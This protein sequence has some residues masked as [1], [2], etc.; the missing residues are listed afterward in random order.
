MTV[1]IVSDSRATLYYGQY[2]FAVSWHQDEIN[3]IRGLDAKHLQSNIRARMEFER[4]R[5]VDWQN[6]KSIPYESKFTRACR[7][8]LESI[9]DL[10]SKE[11]QIKLVLT[12]H[13]ATVYTNDIGIY[14]RLAACSWIKKFYVRQV[15]LD[16][17]PGTVML[18][19]PQYQYR[20]YFRAIEVSEEQKKIMANWIK[21]QGTEIAASPSVQ[22][23]FGLQ[24]R[25]L[26]TW[27]SFYTAAH[28]YI[29][30]NSLQYESMLSMICP[31]V[32][33][34]TMLIVQKP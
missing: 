34:K 14:Q 1:N 7:S 6:R 17:V 24:E 2:E 18:K 4:K 25:Q 8:N 11:T 20:T 23:F 22:C 30:H 21:N 12:T 5:H 15:K 3:C 32:I 29:D 27:S 31:G 9:R 16:Q 26:R 13:V 19:N 28:Y 33:R 10:L